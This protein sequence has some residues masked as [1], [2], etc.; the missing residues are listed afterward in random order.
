MAIDVIT[1]EIISALNDFSEMVWDFE[2]KFLH[3]VQ[4]NVPLFYNK[5][6]SDYSPPLN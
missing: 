2:A 3:Y 4:K 6:H 1:D 5:I